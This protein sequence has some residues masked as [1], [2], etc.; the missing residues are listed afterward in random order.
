ESMASSPRD[1]LGYRHLPWAEGHLRRPLSATVAADKDQRAAD[2]CRAQRGGAELLVHRIRFAKFRERAVL[3][4]DEGE[5]P[6][7]HAAR[8]QRRARPHQRF[9]LA[10]RRP[11]LLLRRRGDTLLQVAGKAR[12][13]EADDKQ[14]DETSSHGS[15]DLSS[16]PA[17]FRTELQATWR[18]I[19]RCNSERRRGAERRSNGFELIAVGQVERVEEHVEPDGAGQLE[20]L[21]HAHVIKVYVG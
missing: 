3:V 10:S 6:Y 20:L 9:R 11:F 16:L 19:S 21:L 2:E 1:L 13:G 15:H 12:R 7:G 17:E 8:E 18:G 5:Q 4:V 14:H